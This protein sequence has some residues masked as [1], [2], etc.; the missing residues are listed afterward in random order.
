MDDDEKKSA[1]IIMK[2]ASDI[3]RAASMDQKRSIELVGVADYLESIVHEAD[4]EYDEPLCPDAPEEGSAR[5]DDVKRMLKPFRVR[6]S[7]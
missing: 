3:R 6:L 4:L 1:E 2:A 5:A 7:R